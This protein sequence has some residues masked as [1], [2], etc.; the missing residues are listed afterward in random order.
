MTGNVR[1]APAAAHN[2]YEPSIGRNRSSMFN[3]IYRPRSDVSLSI[4]YRRLRTFMI[5]G[6]SETADHLNMSMG[7]LF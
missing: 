7:V 6:N 1:L 3:F 2:Y 4:E 5:H